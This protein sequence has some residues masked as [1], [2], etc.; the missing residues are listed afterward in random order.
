MARRPKAEIALDT[1]LADLPP[2]LRWREWMGR[3]EAV[4]FAAPE[5]VSRA[6]LAQIVGR[7][8]ALDLL[9]ADIREELR[10]RP[11]DL[12]AV[13]GGWHHRT[14]NVFAPAIRAVSGTGAPTA[15]LSSTEM[16]FLS[17]IAYLQPIT[18]G[19][20][21]KV[22]GKEMSRDIV[23]ALK[24]AGVIAAGPRSPE[25]GA[26]YTYVTTEKFLSVFGLASLRELP[27]IE[28]LE[29]AGLLTKDNL[30]AGEIPIGI[31]DEEDE[32][33]PGGDS[34]DEVE[35]ADGWEP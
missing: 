10:G 20:L 3:V 18:R 24:R 28:K 9:I 14:R 11:Y 13:A 32:G 31:G 8:C 16:L 1:E 23:A 19:E 12:V 17:G 22:F 34:I 25:P 35:A 27:D 21:G 2:E 7:D 4:I 33:P 5:P 26:P 30:L 6:V 15:G 29:D